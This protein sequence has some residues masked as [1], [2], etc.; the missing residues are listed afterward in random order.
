[1]VESCRRWFFGSALEL[2]VRQLDRG[3]EMSQGL[4]GTA[5]RP[6]GQHHQHLLSLGFSEHWDMRSREGVRV[7]WAFPPYGL[8][9]WAGLRFVGAR[10]CSREHHCSLT[11]A[12]Y[13][14]GSSA[15]GKEFQGP[16]SPESLD[17]GS[18]S[19]I[20]MKVMP[21]VH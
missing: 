2:C 10:S 8:V 6:C 12:F 3:L 11:V 19:G 16:V 7:P 4:D 20:P 9:F 14:K 5:T 18:P 1:M 13:P 15:L 21:G 17:C